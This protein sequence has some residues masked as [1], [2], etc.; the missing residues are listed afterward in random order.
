MILLDSI[1]DAGPA[2]RGAVAL[3]G[4]HGGRF[5][6]AVASRAGLRAAIFS[7]AGGGLDGA[8]V[9]GLAALD[10]VGMAAAAT[11]AG[12][13]RIGSAADALDR[14]RLSGVNA[15]AA[16]LGLRAG[17]PVSE[18]VAALDAAPSPS[19]V[20]PAVEEARRT[21]ALP[22]GLDL[23]LLDSASLVGPED[24]GAVVITGSHGGLVGGRPERALKAAARLA[25]FNDAGVGIEGVG[26]TRLPALEER[27]IAAV[28]VGHGTA[29]IGE[30]ASTYGT[31]V[32]S[33]ANAAAR[34]L[35]LEEGMRLRAALDRLPPPRPA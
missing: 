2:H 5:P 12:T 15:A 7:D 27:G 29:R 21:L 9:A 6:A 31:G 26:I 35:G 34:A 33:A 19:G 4:S 17:M 8:G 10:T 16:R 23:R 14:G 28:A 22:S 25:A 20:L 3:S 30:T 11:D 1:T 32:I 24:A 18:A 13:C